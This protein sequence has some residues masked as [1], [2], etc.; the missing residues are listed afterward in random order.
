MN[1]E[2][3]KWV[4]SHKMERMKFLE[5]LKVGTVEHLKNRGLTIYVLTDSSGE[6]VSFSLHIS[7]VEFTNGTLRVHLSHR[8]TFE[9]TNCSRIK[10]KFSLRI[11]HV[12]FCIV[13]GW[14][15][16]CSAKNQ[17]G[18]FVLRGTMI[19]PIHVELGHV[20]GD[21]HGGD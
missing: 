3:M 10:T 14:T 1:A 13:R 4:G 9:T 11:E 16:I 5:A 12:E 19:G 7:C 17:S 21:G 20:Y 15:A 6:G 18:E 8:P 2:F